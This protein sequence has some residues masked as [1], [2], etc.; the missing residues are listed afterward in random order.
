MVGPV[1]ANCYIVADKNAAEAIVI[2]PGSDGEKILR[3]IKDLNLKIQYIINTHA[4][5]DHIEA[6]EY[7]KNNLGCKICMHEADKNMLS[8][9]NLNLSYMLYPAEK[10]VF[11]KPDIILKDKDTIKAGNMKIS[12]IHTPGHTP[13]S[14]CLGVDKSL[15]TGD[16]LFSGSIGT[17]EVPLADYKTLINSIKNKIL[18]LPDDTRIYPGHGNASTIGTEKKT[19][20]F[21][22]KG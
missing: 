2:D 9:T 11:P 16:T 20:P 13:G 10:M 15:F 22:Q 4:H 17:T 3:T 5:I 1:Q 12:V 14:I 6:N 8:D 7:L 21:L 18:T 19:N